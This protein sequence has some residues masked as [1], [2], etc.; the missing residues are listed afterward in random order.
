MLDSSA[1]IIHDVTVAREKCPLG[2]DYVDFHPLFAAHGLEARKR[3][4]RPD[5]IRYAEL[6]RRGNC[7]FF[8]A[9]QNG[10]P[11]G[12]ACHL[13]FRSMHFNELLGHDDFWYVLPELRGRGIGTRLRRMGL[14]WMK[15]VGVVKV[16]CLIYRDR[17][18]RQLLRNLGYR[19]EG[20]RW[21][22]DITPGEEF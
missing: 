1:H 2:P 12:Y 6:E 18:N 11:V 13:A 22:R 4:I 3:V 7:A 14:Q 20:I 10:V 21:V 8:A 16:E 5:M 9:R 15:S 19:R 17:A